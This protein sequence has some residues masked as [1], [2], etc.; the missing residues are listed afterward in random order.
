MPPNGFAQEIRRARE[1]KGLPT[2]VLGVRETLEAEEVS[3]PILL[4][5]GNLFVPI[6]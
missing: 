5:D 1:K 3:L 4:R 6:I 2:H